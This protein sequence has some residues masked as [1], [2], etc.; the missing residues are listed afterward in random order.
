MAHIPD[1]KPDDDE[2]DVY[3][4]THPGKVRTENQDHFLL[5]ALHKRFT[6]LGSSLSEAQLAP[7]ADR[8]LAFLAGGG[9]MGE[10]TRAFDWSQTPVGP[11]S[12]WPQSL[13]TAVRIMLN[14]RYPMFVW[15]GRG[16][17]KFYNDAYIPMLGQRHPDALGRS[18]AEVWSDVWPVVGPQTEAVLN[19]RRTT[20]SFTPTS[21]PT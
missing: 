20:P 10:R 16:L 2:I 4:L 12:E 5:A 15:W 18:A 9:E 13:K 7:Y 19:E 8:R 6:V 1:R 3:G 21:P 17:T 14:S 11:A